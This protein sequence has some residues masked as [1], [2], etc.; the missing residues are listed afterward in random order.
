MEN[1]MCSI[2]RRILPNLIEK[3]PSQVNLVEVGVFVEYPSTRTLLLK[4]GS[5]NFW[6]NIVL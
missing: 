4:Y 1:F 3:V 2:R 5:L 6:D